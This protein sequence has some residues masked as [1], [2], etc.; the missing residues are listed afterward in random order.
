ML[1][2]VP[3][4]PTRIRLF[5]NQFMELTTLTPFP[6]FFLIWFGILSWIATVALSHMGWA[7]LV[8]ALSF[9]VLLWT[10]AEYTMHRFLFH[11]K[12]KSAYGRRLLFLLHENHHAD[13]ADPLRGIMPLTVSIP[14]GAIFWGLAIV[15]FGP[16][17]HAVFLGFG[18]GYL[19]YDTTHWACHQL[20]MQGGIAKRLKQH[21][22]RHHYAEQDAN[23]ATTGIFWDRVFRTG[24]KRRLER[25]RAG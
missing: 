14:L 20:P 25:R 5:Q 13:P 8:V 15:A 11:M 1:F 3:P 16:L 9:G 21:H 19:M 23:Y 7:R 18:I 12:I 6:V 24:M 4:H 22:L 10:L 17:G 2:S